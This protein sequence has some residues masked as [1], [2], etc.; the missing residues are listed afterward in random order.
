MYNSG[1]SIEHTVGVIVIVV[2]LVAAV[3]T[4]DDAMIFKR[5]KRITVFTRLVKRKKKKLKP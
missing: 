5:Q 1:L 3:A 2:A 4:L